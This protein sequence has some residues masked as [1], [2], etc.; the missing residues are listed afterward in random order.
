MTAQRSGKFVR[1]FAATVWL[2]TIVGCANHA[3]PSATSSS[4]NPVKATDAFFPGPIDTYGQKLTQREIDKR[5]VAR[6]VRRIDLCGFIDPATAAKTIPGATQYGYGPNLAT[7]T[8]AQE[9]SA[10][11]PGSD[12]TTS[13]RKGRIFA[14]FTPNGKFEASGIT[15]T[16]SSAG[17]FCID[18]F[19]LDL[20]SLPGAPK[21]PEVVADFNDR[22]PLIVSSAKAGDPSCEQAKAVVT[23]AARIRASGLPLLD[24]QSPIPVPLLANDPC[25]VFPDLAG[26]AQ[27]TANDADP[28]RCLLTADG[29]TVPTAG[30]TFSDIAAYLIRDAPASSMEQRDGVTLYSGLEDRPG[31]SPVYVVAGPALAPVR[32]DQHAQGPTDG[33]LPVVDVRGPDCEQTKQVAIAAAKKFA[34]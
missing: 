7:C 17:P 11:R 10:D 22:F 23:A 31:C 15:V 32:F 9:P 25:A 6:A 26:F 20:A 16:E 33:P 18:M 14:D 19:H 21:D 30:L 4:S 5:A 29:A 28:F 12:V 1:A 3:P 34:R 13:L 24:A 27:Y 2:M 8:V